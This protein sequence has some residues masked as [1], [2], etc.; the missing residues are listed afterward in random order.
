MLGNEHSTIMIYYNG[1]ERVIGHLNPQILKPSIK[2]L[3]T[4]QYPDECAN[5]PIKGKCI[6]V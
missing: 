5:M 6:T 2:V 3:I 1:Q 4:A